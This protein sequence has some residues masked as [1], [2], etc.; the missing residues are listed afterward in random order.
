MSDSVTTAVGNAEPRGAAAAGYQNAKAPLSDLFAR[1]LDKTAFAN[2]MLP[3][4]E[5]GLARAAERNPEINQAADDAAQ[6]AADAAPSE[7]NVAEVEETDDQSHEGDEAEAE[8]E[9]PSEETAQDNEETA[10]QEAALPQDVALDINAAS[11]NTSN[12]G[13]NAQPNSASGVV[14]ETKVEGPT[15]GQ[16]RAT[17]TKGAVQA[18]A[19]NGANTNQAHTPAHDAMTR[20][21]SEFGKAQSGAGVQQPDAAAMKPGLGVDAAGKSV[22]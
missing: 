5:F 21:N 19:H 17:A 12:P 22:V 16:A 4:S 10:S 11:Q 9:N 15:P 18:A 3:Q 14:L 8:T 20:G 1:V 7:D 2:S 13:L 6:D